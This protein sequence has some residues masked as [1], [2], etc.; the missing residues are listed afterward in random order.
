MP[1]NQTSSQSKWEALYI[2]TVVEIKYGDKFNSSKLKSFPFSTR[3]K[4]LY[5]VIFPKLKQLNK[6]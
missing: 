2:K 3:S 4:L 6:F 1:L 5:D